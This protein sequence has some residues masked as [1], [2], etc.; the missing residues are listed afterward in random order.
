MT[1]APFNIHPQNTSHGRS[2]VY[3]NNLYQT[4][5]YINSSNYTVAQFSLAQDGEA[6]PVADDTE[7]T[8]GLAYALNELEES[9]TQCFVKQSGASDDTN[10]KY[11]KYRYTL[12]RE[13]LTYFARTKHRDYFTLMLLYSFANT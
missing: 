6:L 12:N 7:N 5:I 1:A 13:S 10:R 11:V 8:I 9:Y 2:A 3:N 4:T